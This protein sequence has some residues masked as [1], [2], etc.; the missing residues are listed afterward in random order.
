MD[1][2]TFWEVMETARIAVAGGDE[3]FDEA[4]VSQL[5]DRPEQEILEYAQ[6][7]EKAHDALYRWDVWAAVCLIGGGCSDDGFIDFRAGV[8][9]LGREWYEHVA[10]DPDSLAAHPVVARGGHRRGLL[11]CVELR[12][13]RCL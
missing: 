10:A 11:G 1:T 4:L 13:Q 12:G 6:R 3:P 9:A 7:F 5:A 8:I 2:D